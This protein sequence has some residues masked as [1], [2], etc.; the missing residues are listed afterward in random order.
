MQ[1]SKE[2]ARRALSRWVSVHVGSS[3]WRHAALCRGFDGM[4]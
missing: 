4:L 2:K 3:M 1:E